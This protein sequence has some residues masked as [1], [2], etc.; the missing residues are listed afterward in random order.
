MTDKGAA[1]VNTEL[2]GAGGR[3]GSRGGVGWGE[4]GKR[5]QREGP[6]RRASRERP[7]L[8][9]KNESRSVLPTP[10]VLLGQPHP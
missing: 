7:T 8:A 9:Q 10:T 1:F 2:G 6:V 5:G 3:R 4:G